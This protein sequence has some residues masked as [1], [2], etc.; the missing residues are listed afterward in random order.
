MKVF[1][2]NGVARSGK[3][4]F[5]KFF[6]ETDKN[7]IVIDISTIDPIVDAMETLGIE[8]EKTDK[9][10]KFAS[11][12]KDMC[13]KTFDVSFKYVIETIHDYSIFKFDTF[14]FVHCRE[15]HEI[16]RLKIAINE[17]DI[18]CETILIIRENYDHV[19][20]NHADQNVNNYEYDH[21]ISADKLDELK[22][23]ATKFCMEQ[24][25]V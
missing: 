9:W 4:S 6:E 23:K 10:R 20:D 14:L 25:Y 22:E 17:M 3:N 1:I 24:K 11:D 2:L 12:L 13:T 15:P 21:V 19:P 16:E 5:V 7:N 8:Y 18:D